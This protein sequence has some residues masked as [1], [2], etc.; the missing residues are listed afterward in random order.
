MS[1]LLKGKGREP[2]QLTYR[3]PTPPPPLLDGIQTDEPYVS[4][5]AVHTA[6][7]DAHHS[8]VGIQH[9]DFPYGVPEDAEYDSASDA[10]SSGTA[11]DPE[12]ASSVSY[13]PEAQILA[14]IL[15]DGRTLELRWLGY[16]NKS[17][18][19]IKSDNE[20]LIRISFPRTL[21]NISASKCLYVNPSTGALTVVLLDRQNGIYRLQFDAPLRQLEKGYMFPLDRHTMFRSTI[22]ASYGMPTR[23][24][25]DG[26]EQQVIWSV[27]SDEGVAIGLEGCLL[28]CLWHGQ[29]KHKLMQ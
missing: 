17:S 11:Q 20:T 5:H 1:F 9:F 21:R 15:G 6:F 13:L 28:R 4:Y 29:G 22:D 3:S 24:H 26:P 23:R 7:P 14:R 8:D 12:L 18:R 2:A 19:K 25:R 16:V 10:N 27:Y